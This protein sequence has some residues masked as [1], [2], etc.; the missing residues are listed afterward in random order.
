MPDPRAR[1]VV[2]HAARILHPNKRR[3]LVATAWCRQQQSEGGGSARRAAAMYST[4]GHTSIL[5]TCQLSYPCLLGQSICCSS[6][7]GA[8]WNKSVLQTHRSCTCMTSFWHKGASRHLHNRESSFSAVTSF[9]FS[10]LSQVG[11][12]LDTRWIAGRQAGLAGGQ[13]L[14]MRW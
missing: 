13:A 1:Q 7:Q 4:R 9:L 6:K 11:C 5:I 10:T 14:H 12:L 3:W 2:G 8:G